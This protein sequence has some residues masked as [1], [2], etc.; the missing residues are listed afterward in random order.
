[1]QIQRQSG[2]PLYPK[3]LWN[4]PISRHGAGR[5]LI[6]GGHR[7]EFSD[8]QAIYQLSV[9]AGIGQVNV[10]MPDSLQR[11]LAG[12]PGAIFVPSSPSGSLGK[13]SLAEILHQAANFDALLI[14]PNLSNNSETAILFESIVGKH[15]GKL[16]VSQDALKAAQHRIDLLT[17]NPNCLIVADMPEVFKLA[18]SAGIPLAIRDSGVVSK[19]EILE[20]V[21]KSGQANYLL[22]GRDM[23]VATSGKQSL[24]SAVS[25]MDFF[26]SASIATAS[27]WFTQNPK[28]VFAGL[29]TAAYILAQARQLLTQPNEEPLTVAEIEKAIEAVLTRDNF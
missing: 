1:M 23:I 14:G 16:I 8:V 10:I 15:Q 4:R 26:A 6:V 22:L 29:T 25:S 28:D 12:A 27:V 20:T 11:L 24:T 9:A 2:E 17:N 13:A 19:L 3:L 5:L 21:A 18:G 7:N